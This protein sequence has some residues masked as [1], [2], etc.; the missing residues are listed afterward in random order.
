LSGSN[1]N[2]GDFGTV[3]NLTLNNGAGNVA[4]PPGT[5]GAF[6]SN[7]NTSFVLGVAGATEAAVYNLQ[8]LTVNNG[9]SLQIVGPVV[10]TLANGTTLGGAVGN[11]ARPEWL[12]L[13]VA[14]GGLTLNSGVAVRGALVVPNGTITLNGTASIFGEL[15]SDRLSV[16]SGGLVDE[17]TQ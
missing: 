4:V 17:F 12:T 6:T 13:R 9:S 1:K 14:S 16:S 15:V 3:R 7:G 11:A 5:Y 2:A 10:L 8:S